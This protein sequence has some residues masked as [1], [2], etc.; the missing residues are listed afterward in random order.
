MPSIFLLLFGLLLG[1]ASAG[2]ELPPA[3][4][5]PPVP[6]PYAPDTVPRF[7]SD[8]GLAYGLGSLLGSWPD[9][10]VHG[11]AL[12]R[13]EVFLVDR[14]T[15]GP[16]LGLSVWGASSVWPLQKASEEGGPQAEPFS[17]RQYGAMTALRFDP[18]APVGGLFG[19]GFGRT[20]LKSYY[21]GP[22]AIPTLSF[23]GGAR[24]RLEGPAF[25]DLLA[26]AS[27]GTTRSPTALGQ[28]EWWMV[29]LA[30]GPGLHLR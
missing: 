29:Q 11:F 28:H 9:P 15:P 3:P 21:G 1:Q 20:D 30:L 14:E 17:L 8:L 23:E 22:L 24:L 19:I 27:W 7:G 25:L 13:Y 26:R 6:D 4:T 16:R 18:Q 10:G 2:D 12:A 5:P